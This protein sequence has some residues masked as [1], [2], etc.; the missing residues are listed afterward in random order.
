MPKIEETQE[1]WFDYPDDPLGGRVLIRHLK[2]GEVAR[3]EN[4]TTEVRSVFNQETN[5]PE[6]IV[7]HRA[8]QEKLAAAAVK[9][10]EKFFDGKPVKGHAN[11]KPLP[12]NEKNIILFCKEDGFLNFVFDSRKKLAEHVQARREESEKN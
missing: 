9:D 4:E 6:T 7:I 5:Q 8:M 2:S 12:C 10:W 3:I 11:G 1:M